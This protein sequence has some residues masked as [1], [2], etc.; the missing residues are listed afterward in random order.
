MSRSIQPPGASTRTIDRFFGM[1]SDRSGVEMDENEFTA[2][3]NYRVDYLRRLKLRNGSK[4]QGGLTHTGSSNPVLGLDQFV[5][6]DGSVFDLKVVNTVLYKS[7]DGGAWASLRTGLAAATTFFAS[8]ITKK[9]GAGNEESDTVDSSTATTVTATSLSMTEAEHVGKMLVINGENKYIKSNTATKITVA[10]R[11]DVVP[12]AGDAFTVVAT[13]KECFY[14]NGTD[15][16]K[17]DGTTQTVLDSSVH[18]YVFDGVVEYINRLWGWR[19]SDLHFSDIGA[20]EHFSRNALY[21]YGSKIIVA[22]TFGSMLA[23]WESNRITAIDGDN[24]DHWKQFPVSTNRGTDSQLSVATYA[25]MQFGLNKDLGVII[26][27]TDSL[28]P[29]G[30]E[31][32]S[33][34]DEYITVEILAHTDAEINAACGEVADSKYH[35]TVGTDHYTLHIRES[36][37]APRNDAGGIRWI[38]TKD[39]YPG[40]LVA[41][42]LRLMGTQLIAGSDTDGQLYEYNAAATYD[43]DGTAIA[44]L[45]EK[46]YWR[47]RVDERRTFFWSLKWRQDTTAAQVNVVVSGDPDGVTYGAALATIDLNTETS[48]LHEVKFTAN[49]DDDKSKGYTMSY[50]LVTSTSILVPGIEELHLLYMPDPLG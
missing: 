7:D 5:H 24:P 41:N 28:N 47:P 25:N 42:I 20:G 48:N 37:N 8:M 30:P 33:V 16:E 17:T 38:W 46:Q 22:K 11:F 26:I 1:V 50:K 18:A 2:L 32:L 14:A 13:Q 9:T 34:S 4:K 10:E 39:S 6:E 31:P 12:S 44:G 49:P 40:A 19:G 36:L 23:V 35:L 43:D 45:I 21:P 29:G 15:F 27:S 3:T